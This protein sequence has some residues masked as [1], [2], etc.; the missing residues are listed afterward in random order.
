[1]GDGDGVFVPMIMVK[2]TYCVPADAY[3]NALTLESFSPAPI[4]YTSKKKKR[5]IKE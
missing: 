5:E 4:F 3:L 2:N 1:M